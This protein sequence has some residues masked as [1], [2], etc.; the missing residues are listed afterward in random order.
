LQFA[1]YYDFIVSKPPNFPI[2][3]SLADYVIEGGIPEYYKPEFG[4]SPFTP[5]RISLENL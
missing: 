1:E 3:T 5:V 2:S 4:I